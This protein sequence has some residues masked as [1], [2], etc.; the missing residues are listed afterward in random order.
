MMNLEDAKRNL[1]VEFSDQVALWAGGQKQ[2]HMN[3]RFA[4]IADC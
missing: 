1:T 2:N 3:M 4:L